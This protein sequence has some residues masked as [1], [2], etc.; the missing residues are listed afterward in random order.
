MQRWRASARPRDRRHP[1]ARQ[2]RRWQIGSQEVLPLSRCTENAHGRAGSASVG[3]RPLSPDTGPLPPFR[4]VSGP[5]RPDTHPQAP[6]AGVRRDAGEAS[7]GAPQIA[8][9]TQPRMR[10]RR[11]R[12]RAGLHR[13]LRTA[14]RGR[15]GT[16]FRHR[17]QRRK[18]CQPAWSKCSFE[19]SLGLSL[20]VVKCR[21]EWRDRL[22]NACA[23]AAPWTM[24]PC[25]LLLAL[26]PIETPFWAPYSRRAIHGDSKADHRDDPFASLCPSPT[27]YI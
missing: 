17:S 1:P 12:G 22:L 24:A 6:D 23:Q 27:P 3:A 8:E 13:S 7:V 9:S 2:D 19:G 15:A 10:A 11:D 25:E 16:P 14:I 4:S 26:L 20:L 21:N 18:A 5:S